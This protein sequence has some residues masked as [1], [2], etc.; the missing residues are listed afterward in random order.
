MG[1]REKSQ[2]VG[3]GSTEDALWM[4]RW[5]RVE[6]LDE[7]EGEKTWKR[8]GEGKE[9]ERK[10]KEHILSSLQFCVTLGIWTLRPIEK[11]AQ[12]QALVR[13]G[14][15]CSEKPGDRKQPYD[16][17]LAKVEKTMAKAPLPQSPALE[18]LL[19]VHPPGNQALLTSLGIV[20]DLSVV[21]SGGYTEEHSDETGDALGWVEIL[22]SLE[23]SPASHEGKV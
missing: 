17:L 2:E 14:T 1:L 11:L 16:P 4:Q 19:P 22:S 21:D 13:S 7:E 10:M 5:K 12:S 18:A 20:T 15:P 3:R 6:T 9:K 23:D 8:E